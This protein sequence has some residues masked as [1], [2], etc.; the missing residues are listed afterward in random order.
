MEHKELKLNERAHDLWMNEDD[1][2]AIIVMHTV[3]QSSEPRFITG[4]PYKMHTVESKLEDILNSVEQER[5]VCINSHFI[6]PHNIVC[7]KV[8]R[9]KGKNQRVKFDGEF[10]E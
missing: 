6:N 1:S 2:Y 4:G 3:N 9:W 5:F 7:V 8:D 10:Y